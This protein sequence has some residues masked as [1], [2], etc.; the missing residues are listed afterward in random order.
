MKVSVEG[1]YLATSEDL[2]Q[3]AVGSA[4]AEANLKHRTFERLNQACRRV[5]TDALGGQTGDHG[6]EYVRCVKP[7][8]EALD[9]LQSW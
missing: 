1:E 4:F 9:D 8:D 2:P 7:D 6:F 5:N 3:M